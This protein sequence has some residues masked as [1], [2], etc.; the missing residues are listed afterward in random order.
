MKSQFR[1]AL[2]P[3]KRLFV[4][5]FACECRYIRPNLFAY[6]AALLNLFLYGTNSSYEPTHTLII[7]I[8]QS[9]RVSMSISSTPIYVRLI[10]AIHHPEYSQIVCSC[11]SLQ[12]D[13]SKAFNCAISLYQAYEEITCSQRTNNDEIIQTCA[14]VM[15]AHQTH[16]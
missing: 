5:V 15:H 7:I 6:K 14:C 9:S 12:S 3:R 1:I 13:E 16:R 10:N 4:Y 11:P 8:V 2:K